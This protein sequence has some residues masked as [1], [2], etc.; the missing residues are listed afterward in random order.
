[1]RIGDHTPDLVTF[2]ASR[3]RV[4][5]RVLERVHPGEAQSLANHRDVGR[6]VGQRERSGLANER[7]SVRDE[8]RLNDVVERVLDLETSGEEAVVLQLDGEVAS[9][10][11]SGLMG[12]ESRQVAVAAAR[13]AATVTIRSTA[14]VAARSAAAVASAAV[15]SVATRWSRHGYFASHA[16]VRWWTAFK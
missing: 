8:K 11:E 9:R 13:S 2:G 12:H 4:D 7:Q 14:T 3:G 15:V 10:R 6:V 1:M 5:A 16:R